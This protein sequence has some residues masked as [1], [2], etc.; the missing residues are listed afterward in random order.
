M[1]P[2]KLTP[3]KQ[4]RQHCLTSCGGSR[5]EVRLCSSTECEFW[6][7]RFGMSQKAVLRQR[8]K[9]FK[10]YFNKTNFRKG[11]NTNG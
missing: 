7:L 2:N 5:K 1:D 10:K 11:E 4:I 8:G 6:E 9:G 3:L